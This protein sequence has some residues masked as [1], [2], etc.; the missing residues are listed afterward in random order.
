[1]V[2]KTNSMRSIQYIFCLTFCSTVS[3][4]ISVKSC[5]SYDFCLQIY[6]S[7]ADEIVW[8]N[9]N[10]MSSAY[11]KAFKECIGLHVALQSPVLNSLTFLILKNILQFRV[12]SVG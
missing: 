12:F 9:R 5:H 7:D 3:V 6:Y 2:V 8:V 11:D 1:M 10:A 4:Q